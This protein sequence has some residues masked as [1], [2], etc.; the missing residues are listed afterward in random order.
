LQVVELVV[1][2][3]AQMDLAEAVLEAF[4]LAHSA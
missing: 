1:Q 2:L 4:L 3:V